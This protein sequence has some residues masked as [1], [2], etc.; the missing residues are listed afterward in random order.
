MI[1][2]RQFVAGVSAAATIAVVGHGATFAA[3]D[4]GKKR[5]IVTLSFDD[6]FKKSSSK[7]AEIYE[8]HKLSA[9]INVV[10]SGLHEGFEPTSSSRPSG[11]FG[12]WNELQSAGATRS[13]PT[14]TGTK[15]CKALLRRGEGP[16]PPLPGR[17][18]QE[19]RRLRPQAGDL[20]FPVQRLDARTGAVAANA[21]ACVP[22][23]RRSDQSAAAQGADEAD[24]HELRAGQ[25]RKGHRPGDREVAGAGIRLADLQ[26]PRPGRRRAGG[27]S[28]QL[29]WSSCWS[30]C[31]PSRR[32]RSCLRARRWRDSLDSACS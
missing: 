3:D 15:T 25:L 7:T 9:C 14:A 6:G 8:K 28:E 17:V 30:G 23:G 16:D 20:Q 13:C 4:P 12:L 11:D 1:T 5:H 18:R 19:T 21:G 32:W 31:W 2:R 27:R 10:A 24:L 22:N 26:H 29:T